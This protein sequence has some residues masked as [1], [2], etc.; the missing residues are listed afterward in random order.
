MKV[1]KKT[2][3]KILG[4]QEEERNGRPNSVLLDVVKI[5]RRENG[6]RMFSGTRKVLNMSQKTESSCGPLYG[7]GDLREM[8]V[9]GVCGALSEDRRQ[10]V[11]RRT[12]RSLWVDFRVGRTLKFLCRLV[13][14]GSLWFSMGAFLVIVWGSAARLGQYGESRFAGGQWFERLING[15]KLVGLM[16]QKEEGGAISVD[17]YDEVVSFLEFQERFDEIEKQVIGLNKKLAIMSERSELSRVDSSNKESGFR[18]LMKGKVDQLESKLVREIESVR[19]DVSAVLGHFN[20]SMAG[21]FAREGRRGGHVSTVE[22]LEGRIRQVSGSIAEHERLV[23][24]L[25]VDLDKLSEEVRLIDEAQ[26]VLRS[27]VWSMNKRS[28][29]VAAFRLGGGSSLGGFSPADGFRA[30][31]LEAYLRREVRVKLE[32]QGNDQVDWAQ[33]SMGGRVV[34]P[35]RNKYCETDGHERAGPLVMRGL[36]RI[37]S[38]LFGLFAGTGPETPTGAP[39]YSSECFEPS[40]IVKSSQQKS[41]GSCFFSDVGSSVDIQLS[42]LINVTSVG[43]DHVVFPLEYDRGE[44]VPRRFSVR[45]LEGGRES[46]GF[47]YGSFV[48][49]YPQRTG[50]GLQIFQVTSASQ[51]CNRVR[52]TIHSSYGTRHFCLYKLRVYGEMAGNGEKARAEGKSSYWM[53]LFLRVSRTAL[54]IVKTKLWRVYDEVAVGGFDHIRDKLLGEVSEE[55]DGEEGVEESIGFPEPHRISETEEN[56]ERKR[57]IRIKVE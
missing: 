22:E 41:V 20:D 28:E 39:I 6:R 36:V 15:E 51:L 50:E 43:I 1:K 35:L 13:G 47:E 19:E 38:L 18:E 4:E 33:S 32:M 16:K 37:Q 55:E 54:D 27:L 23:L 25:R 9:S 2:E 26:D 46:G 48:Y 31:D 21:Y 8:N 52:F 29:E 14:I 3:G 30:P 17:Q 34:S 5:G 45:C 49:D 10:L 56:R 24:A 42:A 12:E 57:G 40:H 11:S 53:R 7:S 44:T